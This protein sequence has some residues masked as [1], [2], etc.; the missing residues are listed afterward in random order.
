MPLGSQSNK[1]SLLACCWL[2]LTASS[3]TKEAKRRRKDLHH[4][5]LH[6]QR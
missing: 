5:D 2:S 4:K 6:K 1:P 3:L